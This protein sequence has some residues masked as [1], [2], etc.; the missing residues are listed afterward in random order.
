MRGVF[1]LVL[2]VVMVV[3]ELLVCVCCCVAE[4]AVLL[5]L[6]TDDTGR[7]G[8]VSSDCSSDSLIANLVRGEHSRIILF[9]ADMDAA[10]R[11]LLSFGGVLGA[12]SGRG[13]AD[14]GGRATTSIPS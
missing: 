5:L 6:P 9:P 2:A 3:A 7:G 14:A 13:G 11:R 8:V 1:F 10:L 12:V 4:V